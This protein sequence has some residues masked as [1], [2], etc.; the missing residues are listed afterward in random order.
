MDRLK[1]TAPK[2]PRAGKRR[3]VRQSEGTKKSDT[4]RVK[5]P[6]ARAVEEMPKKMTQNNPEAVSLEL[7][8]TYSDGLSRRQ[9]LQW[10]VE[11]ITG[12]GFQLGVTKIQRAERTHER[13]GRNRRERKEKRRACAMR[14]ESVRDLPRMRTST[15]ECQG[16]TDCAC[17]FM[18]LSY[19]YV[20]C[21]YYMDEG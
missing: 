15:T 2:R 17:S 1:K 20:L 11:D 19:I 21:A 6:L 13:R 14:N 18:T 3:V 5:V 10:C 12:R 7:P 4:V 8:G 16:I 9:S